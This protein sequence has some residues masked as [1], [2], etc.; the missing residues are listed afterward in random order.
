MGT[1]VIRGDGH[2]A[3]GDSFGVAAVK[4]TFAHVI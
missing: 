4:R 2:C 1:F 3:V